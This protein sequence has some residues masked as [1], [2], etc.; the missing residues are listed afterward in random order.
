MHGNAHSSLDGTANVVSVPSNS[1]RDIGVD[2]T[3]EE[4]A[5]GIFDMRILG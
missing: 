2:T 3:T 4:E 5:S 1:L